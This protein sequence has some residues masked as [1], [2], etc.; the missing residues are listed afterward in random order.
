ML[1]RIL[2]FNDTIF[3]LLKTDADMIKTTG[4]DRFKKYMLKGTE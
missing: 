4:D 2:Y 3:G 1:K